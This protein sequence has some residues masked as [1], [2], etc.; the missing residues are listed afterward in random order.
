MGF[1]EVREGDPGRRATAV[2]L[3]QDH[4]EEMSMKLFLIATTILLLT[5]VV[6]AC[7]VTATPADKLQEDAEQEEW[8]KE[9]RGSCENS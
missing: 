2:C 8:L 4:K 5:L 7:I 9:R 3:K 1:S 6:F